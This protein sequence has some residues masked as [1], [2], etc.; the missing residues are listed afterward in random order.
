[1]ATRKIR[2]GLLVLILLL[3]LMVGTALGKM[4]GVIMPEGAVRSF[5][6]EGLHYVFGPLTLNFVVAAIK[7]EF[8]IDVNVMGVLGVILLAQLLRWY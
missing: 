5:F 2:F 1:M 8:S 7:L 4:L 3:G 6:V